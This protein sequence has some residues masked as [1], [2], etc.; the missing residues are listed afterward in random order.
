MTLGVYRINPRTGERTVLKETRQVK[1][2]GISDHTSRL[3]LCACPQA[4][5]CQERE[6]AAARQAA[7]L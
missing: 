5:R 3:P 1:A 4:P 2:A 7:R 6:A